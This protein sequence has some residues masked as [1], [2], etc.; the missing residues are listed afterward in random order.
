M[1][2]LEFVNLV[3]SQLGW[4]TE[5]DVSA[6]TPEGLKILQVTNTIIASMQNDKNWPEL[7]KTGYLAINAPKTSDPFATTTFGAAGVTLE[8]EADPFFSILDSVG[9]IVQVGAFKPI[10]KITTVSTVRICGFNTAWRDESSSGDTIVMGQDTYSLPADFDRLLLGKMLNMGTGTELEELDPVAMRTEKFNDGF[11]LVQEEARYFTI[12]GLD[13]A[14]YPLVH[15]DR[16]FDK[17]CTISYEYQM[18]HPTLT[19]STD[20]ILYPVKY[21]LYIADSCIAMLQRDVENS[22]NAVQ[23]STDKLQNALRV[24]ANPNNSRDR[25]RI[26]TQGALHGAFRRR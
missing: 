24:G 15:F 14:G 10:Y 9:K 7:R 19:T 26:R 4:G 16:I 1:E 6:P 8:N 18:K 3:S 2:A 22:A 11:G 23:T 13:S 20:P 5:T 12:H 25:M 17:N 21:I